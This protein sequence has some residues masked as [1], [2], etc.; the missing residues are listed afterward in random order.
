MGLLDGKRTYRAYLSV[1]ITKAKYEMV[2]RLSRIVTA[3][4]VLASTLVILQPVPGELGTTERG[5]SI[6]K[7]WKP[8]C[9]RSDT[10]KGLKKRGGRVNI[11]IE[12]S[13]QE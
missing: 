13:A 9:F 1:R 5:E 8:S 10:A 2:Q 4:V 6:G 12:S 11:R 7:N 3:A